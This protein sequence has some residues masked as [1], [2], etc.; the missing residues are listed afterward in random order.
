MKQ[1]LYKFVLTYH[2]NSKQVY[3]KECVHPKRTETYKYCMRLLD[4][5]KIHRF[6]YY[7]SEK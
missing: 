4:A 6:T 2:D 7:I 5:D 1:K 3:Y